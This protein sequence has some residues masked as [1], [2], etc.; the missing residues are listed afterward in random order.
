[1]K[2]VISLFLICINSFLFTG[3]QTVKIDNGIGFSQMK[4]NQ[5]NLFTKNYCS[6]NIGVGL[7]Y[8]EYKYFYISSKIIYLNRGGKDEMIV[9]NESGESILKNL[10]ENWNFISFNTTLR[11]KISLKEHF[12]YFG[13]GP[14]I[15]VLIGSDNFSNT[16]FTTYK[17][18]KILFG[19]CP[20]LGFNYFLTHKM[21]L[22]LNCA[23][24]HSFIPLVKHDNIKLYNKSFN[25]LISFGYKLK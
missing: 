18:D 25:C 16:G 24:N 19:I 7:E 15:D 5:N 12:F 22:G 8:L 3:A 13:I 1:M 23:Y 4:S 20:E 14:F 10:C 21:Y 6:Y 2:K 17:A 11:T 9:T